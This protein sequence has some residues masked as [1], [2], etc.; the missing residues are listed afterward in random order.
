MQLDD[1]RSTKRGQFG[2]LVLPGHFGEV[3][4]ELVLAT[5]ECQDDAKLMD[6]LRR[7][8][9]QHEY[10]FSAIFA[11]S[12]EGTLRWFSRAIV[13]SPSRMLFLI[14]VGDDYVGH[15][16]LDAFDPETRT[17][18]IDSILRGERAYPGII[19]TAMH[20]LMTWA[21][22]EFG[23]R[24][25]EL[26]VAL[27]NDPAM[28][29]YDRFGFQEMRRWPLIKAFHDDH[30]EWITQPPDDDGEPQRHAVRLGLDADR[31]PSLEAL[32]TQKRPS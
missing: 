6:T 29:L 1:I 3:P 13:E 20:T 8:R 7:W 23:L 5:A 32:A 14:R 17:M 28:A 21:I 9:L 10:W 31:L 4:Y 16:G 2:N 15:V 19:A 24:R 18:D 11:I 30:M 25:F 27:E 22:P 26:T 12:R